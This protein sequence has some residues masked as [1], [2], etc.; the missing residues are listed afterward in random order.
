MK[1][2][3][4]EG[5]KFVCEVPAWADGRERLCEFRNEI[6]L[7]HPNHPPHHFDRDRNVWVELKCIPNIEQKEK[8]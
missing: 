3:T 5:F 8:S 1:Q 7:V 6:F 2:D 4:R